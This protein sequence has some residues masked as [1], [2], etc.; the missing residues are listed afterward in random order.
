MGLESVHVFDKP[1][2]SANLWLKEL[3][4]DMGWDDDHKAYLVLRGA[5]HAL[6]DRLPVN[7]A[8]QLGAQL[9]LIISGV[10]YDGWRPVQKPE[11][12]KHKEDF[13]EKM[14]GPFPVNTDVDFEKAA[15]GVFRLL[16]RKITEG[17][18]DDVVGELPKELKEWWGESMTMAQ[19]R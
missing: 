3:A 7:E 4:E 15:Q 1:L 8:V 6:R 18:L 19:R 2:Q 12:Y 10:Y 14:K 16:A 13:V 5:L 9:P 17:E 11:K